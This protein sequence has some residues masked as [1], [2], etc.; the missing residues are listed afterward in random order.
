MTAVLAF[1]SAGWDQ[2]WSRD[3]QVRATEA[4]ESGDILFFPRLRFPIQ[5]GEERIL[6]PSAALHEK[7]ISLDPASGVLRGSKAGA[8]DRELMR[9]V[10]TRFGR[11][12]GAL[13]RTLLSRYEPELQQARTSFR[14]AEIAGRSASTRTDDT[15]LHVD[16]FPASPTQGRRIL[17]VF[18]NVDPQG[19][20][21]TWRLGEY[22]EDVAS[23]YVRKI[24]K[25]I[26]GLSQCLQWLRITNGR[27][28]AYDYYMLHLHDRMKADSRYQTESPQQLWEFPPDSVW[29]AFTDQVSHAAMSGQYALEQTFHLPVHSMLDPS[30]SPLRILERLLGRALT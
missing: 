19:R 14:P 22:F 2:P 25:P 11:F 24:P 15:R 9:S 10:L 5:N 28:S 20:N 4:L 1:P 13:I 8:N 26:S 7:N 6:S 18:A 21:R 29:I 30:Q 17:R 23:R 12:S 27:R 16:S 3:E